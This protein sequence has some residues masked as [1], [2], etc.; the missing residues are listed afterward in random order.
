MTLTIILLI[1]AIIGFIVFKY[2]RYREN[3]AIREEAILRL[4]TPAPLLPKQE[5]VLQSTYQ[6]VRSKNANRYARSEAVV[7]QSTASPPA[8]TSS[9]VVDPFLAEV[10]S[11]GLG[12]ITEASSKAAMP[13]CC[14]CSHK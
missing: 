6:P 13:D 7:V 12:R 14:S 9:I 10:L 11:S 4:R 3:K 2:A 5:Q 8:P 1:A